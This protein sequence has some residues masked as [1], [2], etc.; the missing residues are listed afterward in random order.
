MFTK[1]IH[2][3]IGKMKRVEEGELNI[4]DV[5]EGEDEVGL[6]DKQ[7]NSMTNRL[8]GVIMRTIYDS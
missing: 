3:L 5:I 7:F 2:L 4:T 1:R 6:L 8:R